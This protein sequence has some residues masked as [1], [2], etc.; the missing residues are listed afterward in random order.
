MVTREL[1]HVLQLDVAGNPHR[2]I[3]YENSAYYYAKNLVAWSMGAVDFTI[4]GGIN[5]HTG[6]RSTLSINTI[7]AIRGKMSE[8]QIQANTRV[9]LSNKTLFGRDRHVCAYCGGSFSY[10]DLTRDHIIPSSRGGVNNWMNCVTSCAGCNKFKD[11]RTPEEAG[12]ELLYVP[13]EPNR[14]EYLILKNRNIL[15]DQMDFLIARVP[16]VSRL[17]VAA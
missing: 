5:A 4:R 13:Y 8:K 9:S 12:M 1:P 7:I 2:W 15:T 3:T 6:N 17:L 10:G 11:D 14:A 16:S